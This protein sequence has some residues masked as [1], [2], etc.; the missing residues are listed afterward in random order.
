MT[1]AVQPE[2]VKP[3]CSTCRH[4]LQRQ[5][6]I[7]GVCMR[8]PGVITTRARAWCANYIPKA[9]GSADGK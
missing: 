8:G 9:E 6:A 1:E 4:W 5:P 2:P 3:E 7:S